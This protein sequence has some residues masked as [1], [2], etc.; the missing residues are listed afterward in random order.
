[1]IELKLR[2]VSISMNLSLNTKLELNN[3]VKMPIL[4]LGTWKMKG[5]DA[6]NSVRWALDAGYRHID[7]AKLYGNEKEIGKVIKESDIPRKEIFLTSK[8]WDSDQG[9]DSTLKAFEKSVKRL[10]TD[11]LDLYLIHWPRDAK[12]KETWKA[13]EKLY[14]EG[15]VKAIGVANYWIHHLKEILEEF[16]ITPAIN[17]FELNPFLYRKELIEFCRDNNI[18]VEA[19][20]PLTH[21]QKLGNPKLKP[22]AKEY[23]KSTAQILIR[24]GLQHE[25]I[26]I[27]KSSQ[28]E[29]IL[30]NSKVFDFELKTEHMEK[31]DNLNE[32]FM[33][34]YDTSKWE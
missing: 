21:G 16:N 2:K 19:Y 15:K 6:I 29:H 4:G 17:Q 12:R 1:M 28:K 33:N 8:V 26:E 11:Y 20:S 32:K 34:L 5:K 13:L 31:L 22:I 23:N 10:N 7:T 14:D 30:E 18:I 9:F 24:W 3:G 27:P 25:F